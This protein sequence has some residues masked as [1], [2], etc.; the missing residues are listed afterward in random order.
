MANLPGSNGRHD[1]LVLQV[2]PWSDDV[3]DKL[4]FDARSPAVAGNLFGQDFLGNTI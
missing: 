4:G 2:R 1:Q 3:L